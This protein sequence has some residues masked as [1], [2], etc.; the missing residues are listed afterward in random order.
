[1]HLVLAFVL[2]SGLI[3]CFSFRYC[4]LVTVLSTSLGGIVITWARTGDYGIDQCISFSRDMCICKFHFS[5]LV[6]DIGGATDESN[7]PKQ[8][9]HLM[10][11]YFSAPVF[12]ED[13]RPWLASLLYF[14]SQQYYTKF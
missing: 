2:V 5:L 9:Q 7:L 4:S 14:S 8:Q 1:M 13:S 11:H 10:R 6:N 12:N 3:C